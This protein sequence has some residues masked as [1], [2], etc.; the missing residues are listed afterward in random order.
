MHFASSAVDRPVDKID[1]A[2]IDALLRQHGSP[3][4][5]FSEAAIR[6]NYRKAFRAFVARYPKVQFAWSYK[7]NYLAAICNIFHSEGSFAEVVS[8]FEYEKARKNGVPSS[9]I[10]FNGPYKSYEILRRAV[11][12]GAQIQIDNAQEILNLERIATELNR[13][14][15]VGIRVSLQTGEQP[16]WRKFGFAYENG[17]ALRTLERLAIGGRLK[18]VGLHAHV[19]RFIDD[20]QQ[21]KTA[22]LKLIDLARQA[23]ER[24]WMSL[25]YLNLGGGFELG[26]AK[27]NQ[28]RSSDASPASDDFAGA[29]CGALN[30]SLPADQAKPTL[31][32]E[33]G[34]ALINDAGYLI[35]TVLDARHSAALT[36]GD[37]TALTASRTSDGRQSAILDA[38]LNLL[39]PFAGQ[40][41][42]VYL[43][44]H[45]E[46]E[47][48]ST[49]LYGPLCM[50]ADVVCD[51]VQLPNLEAGD[52][53]VLH[54]VGA[55]HITHS[56]QFI[57]YRPAVVLIGPAGEI[58]VIRKRESLEHI[59]ALEKVPERFARSD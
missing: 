34:R 15:P 47:K 25:D 37:S 35:S 54:P 51:N 9:R 6:D 19:G 7:T 40:K 31:F 1:G 55:Y 27:P 26:A 22:T 48:T 52:Q 4:Y 5:V 57:A 33:S 30:D 39:P 12:E 41:Y 21:Y 50:N 43:S 17:E 29:I 56:I 8:D 53:I 18:P 46:G 20:P 58:D 13:Q 36:A 42:D 59:E 10:V 38:G 2:C 24:S 49:I 28:P 11:A 32:L 45:H 44:R 14:I 16:A 3:L 23:R